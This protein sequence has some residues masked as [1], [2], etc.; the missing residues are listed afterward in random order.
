MNYKLV[1][2][3]LCGSILTLFACKK[4]NTVWTSDW[5][6]PMVRDTL[7]LQSL[8]TKENLFTTKNGKFYLSA[9]ESF[10]KLN[11]SDYITIPDTTINGI[12]GI[13]FPSLTVYPGTIL[14]E[15]NTENILDFKDAQLK[16]CIIK[17]GE[18]VVKLQNPLAT[19]VIY[20]IE[21]PSL[22]IHG[23]SVKEI[24]TAE[25]GTTSN[26]SEVSIKLNLTDYELDLSG[27]T[28]S[29]FNTIVTTFR[30]QLD[31]N[32]NTVK[33]TNKDNSILDIQLKGIKLSY[34]RGYF[35]NLKINDSKITEIKGLKKVGKE[36]FELES[37]SVTLSI[38]NSCKIN[39]KAKISEL[40]S[41]NDYNKV[42]LQSNQLISPFFISSAT[43]NS[44][45]IVAS[46]KKL[47]FNNTNSN[48]QP[49][50]ENLGN[51]Y[52]VNYAL[53]LNPYGNLSGGWDEF[54]EGSNIELQLKTEIPLSFKIKNLVFKDT[55]DFN[56]SNF[57]QKINS[58]SIQ[59]DYTN[60]F[61][62]SL[63]LK[64]IF[65]KDNGDIVDSIVTKQ[66]VEPRLSY[67]SALPKTLLMDIPGNLLHNLSA[68]KKVIIQATINTPQDKMYPIYEDSKFSFCISPQLVFENQ[69]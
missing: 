25:P 40:S 31:P 20:T 26:P 54:Y 41:I 15:E 1:N 53:E 50:L 5:T 28:K 63:N 59:I 62:Y 9:N 34:A 48:I 3:L 67:E 42:K 60:Y 24:L 52:L 29:G 47:I 43:G 65:L 21:M 69:Y 44:G 22:S 64:L 37:A 27:V 12:I 51:S 45:N 39:G 10:Y 19:K 36:V 32:G 11:L 8:D 14:S 6:F 18:I 13:N 16:K 33:V 56:L 17:E 66:A 46:E 30:L 38:V 23:E 61:P 7:N 35:G 57:K 68:I 2:L 49:F 4:E 55:L 58:G